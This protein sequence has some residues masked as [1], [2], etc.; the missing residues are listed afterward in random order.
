MS[1]DPV[2]NYIR[3][4]N[5]CYTVTQWHQTIQ[6]LLFSKNYHSLDPLRQNNKTVQ[7]TK[8]VLSALSQPWPNNKTV[9]ST[10]QSTQTV[11]SALSQPWPN[12]KTV[13]STRQSTQTVLSALS[14]PWPNNKTVHSTRQS[15]QTVLSAL[16]QP[17][18]NNKTVHSTRQSTQTVLRALSQPWPNNKT[19]HS[20]RQST[21]TVLSALSQ[22]WPNNKT[23]HSTRQSTQTVL[24]ALSQPWPNNKTVHSTRQSTQTVLR[25]SSQPWPRPSTDRPLPLPL[26][27]LTCFTSA[28][29]LDASNVCYRNRNSDTLTND[30]HHCAPQPVSPVPD[31]WMLATYATETETHWQMTATTVHPNLFHQCQTPGCK[32]RMLQKQK[33]WHTDKWQPLEQEHQQPSTAS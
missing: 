18:P 29:L 17:W 23:V 19:V 15:T 7:S 28:R 20:T 14:Q 4:D 24:S 6:A 32:R 2:E 13:H 10:R 1:S 12:N 21:Q 22:P 33:Q 16:S 9:H 3:N 25:A 8:T 27:T 31:S 11:L 5:G 30:S 26:C